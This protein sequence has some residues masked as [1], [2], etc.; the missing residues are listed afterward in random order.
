MFESGAILQYLAG[1]AGCCLGGGTRQQIAVQEWLF[2]QVGGF[3]PMQGQLGHF[4]RA[5]EPTPYAIQR[6]GDEA[7][8]LYGVLE[9]RLDDRDDLADDYSI[10]DVAIYP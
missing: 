7:K 4:K 6:Y 3:G 2:W 1:Q 9:G 5:S 10:A 8:P